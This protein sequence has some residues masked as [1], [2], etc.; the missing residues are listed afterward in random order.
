[1]PALPRL[2][3]VFPC[4][5]CLLLSFTACGPAALSRPR[6]GGADTASAPLSCPV[7]QQGALQDVT[8][9]PAAPYFIHHP[10][11][12]VSTA[13]DVATV[14]FLP[15]GSGSRKIGQDFI[16]KNW[17]SR[18]KGVDKVRII[19]PYAKGEELWSDFTRVRH[20]LE[21]VLV[22]Y[23]GDHGRVHLAGTSN[24]GRHAFQLMLEDG[25]RFASL[26]GAPGLFSKDATDA[27]LK[28]A[29]SRKP[30]YNGVGSRDEDWKREVMATQKRLLGLGL[31]S[32]YVEF[33]DQEHILNER[34]DPSGFFEFWQDAEKAQ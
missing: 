9:T 1:M 27:S 21:E 34:F 23:G 8:T 3:P 33:P 7:A 12:A 28:Q 17:L 30:L 19:I 6:P 2:F 18:G 14:L 26:L 31:R 5:F 13:A 32:Q 16:W 29:L 11:A 10:S 20:V 22:C 24:G 25:S 15:G 4:A